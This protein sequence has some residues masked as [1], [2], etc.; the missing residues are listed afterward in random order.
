MAM[1][2]SLHFHHMF[3]AISSPE[4]AKLAVMYRTQLLV[5]YQNGVLIV[6]FDKFQKADYDSQQMT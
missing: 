1:T 6:S 4:T 5:M 3:C 2:S